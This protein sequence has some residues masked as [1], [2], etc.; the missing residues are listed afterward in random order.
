MLSPLARTFPLFNPIP[1]AAAAAAADVLH[2]HSHSLTCGMD[3]EAAWC[4]RLRER[5]A[6]SLTAAAAAVPILHALA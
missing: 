6:L 1:A 4:A 3:G 5:W 2:A